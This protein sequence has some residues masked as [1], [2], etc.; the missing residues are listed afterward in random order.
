MLEAVQALRAALVAEAG[1][2][3]AA[4][5]G[6]GIVMPGPFGATGLPESGSDLAGWEAIAPAA[7]FSDTLD[8]P[9]I[10]ENDANA[11][12]MAER[13]SGAAQGLETYAFLY[14]GAGLGLGLVHD[15]RL[16][17]GAFGNAGEIGHIPVPSAGR[18]V[19]LEDAVSRLSAQ[20]AMAA[21][22]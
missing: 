17:A 14:F 13:V 8:L 1:L 12:A 15:G 22:G 11:A 16:M 5:L 7:L 4:V 6:A 18:L 2:D 10:V 19:P 20:R 9:V 3:P 21:A